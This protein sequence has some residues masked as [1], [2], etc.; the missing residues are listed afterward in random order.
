MPRRAL[1]PSFV[2]TFALGAAGI[3]SGCSSKGS[4]NRNVS[5]GDSA[6]GDSSIDDSSIGNGGCPTEQPVGG[7]PC[8]L[9]SSITCPYPE[10]TCPWNVGDNLASCQQ[11]KWVVGASPC[12]PPSSSG[13]GSSSGSTIYEAGPDVSDAGADGEGQDGGQD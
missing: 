11:G 12:N 8:D 2:V 1:R 3:A 10:T 4:G 6:I 13:S 9:P 7:A 5:I